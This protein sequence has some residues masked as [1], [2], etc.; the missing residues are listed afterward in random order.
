MA[1]RGRPRKAGERSPCGKLRASQEPDMPSANVGA[2]SLRDVIEGGQVIGRAYQIAHPMDAVAYNRAD[3]PS[4]DGDQWRA[5][6]V[7]SD[8]FAAC[9]A[10][11]RSA[12][13]MSPSGGGGV[14]ASFD[15]RKAHSARLVALSSALPA[16]LVSLVQMVCCRAVSPTHAAET[17]GLPVAFVYKRLGEA[18]DA[19]IA[20]MPMRK[21]A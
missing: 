14:E 1:K 9:T 12:L 20:H 7:Y 19:L 21:A 15:A 11:C 10:S 18:G 17:F 13:D 2:V 8:T 4:I 16:H 5:L 6:K 3:S